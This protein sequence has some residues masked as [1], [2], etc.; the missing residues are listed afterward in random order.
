MNIEAEVWPAKILLIE[1]NPGDIRLTKES[2][3][4]SKIQIN[5]Y[6]VRDGVEAIAFLRK[7]ERYADMPRP[8]LILLDLNLPKKDG[9]EVLVEIKQDPDLKRIP[10]IVLTTSDSED[11]IIN[12]YN[13]HANCYV[14]K[15]LD[16]VHFA[17]VV[18]S[19]ERFWFSTAKL[20]SE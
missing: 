18:K 8:S 11:D 3:K 17:D 16:F 19:I 13:N 1:D 6:A 2:L 4:E 5:L 9:R 14:I 20:S 15:P 10:L 7:E 12:S